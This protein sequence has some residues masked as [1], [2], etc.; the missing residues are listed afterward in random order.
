MKIFGA[1]NQSSDGQRAVA[2][3]SSLAQDRIF[4]AARSSQKTLAA[5]SNRLANQLRDLEAIRAIPAP[6][7]TSPIRA[8][9][10]YSYAEI[11]S[12]QEA[13]WVENTWDVASLFISKL[14]PVELARMSV[15][16]TA[17]GYHYSAYLTASQRSMQKQGYVLFI[18]E[19]IA[20]DLNAFGS[21]Y[22]SHEMTGKE[23]KAMA[24][25]FDRQFTPLGDLGN[26]GIFSTLVGYEFPTA[27][28]KRYANTAAMH[29]AQPIGGMRG[30]GYDA[31]TGKATGNYW[32]I[33]QFGA[34]TYTTTRSKALGWGIDLPQ[35]RQQ[36]TFGQMLVAAYVLAI[37][38]QPAL[39]VRGLPVNESTIY[40]NHNQGYGVWNKDKQR[41]IKQSFWDGQSA[42]VKRLLTSYGFARA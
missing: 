22:S 12:Q 23:I 28:A 38:G 11:R 32:G 35:S 42:A 24:L 37:L 10:P 16:S 27:D 4:G 40:I 7:A 20:G 29:S 25:A 2:S 6:F 13:S 19:K 34:S 18:N 36:M 21:Q 41:K 26:K 3:E 8:R 9:N 15:N 39:V 31:S 14:W 30:G 1:T 5:S 33:T 17:K